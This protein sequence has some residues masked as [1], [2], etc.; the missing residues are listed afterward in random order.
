MDT[1]RAPASLDSAT[2]ADCCALSL[3]SLCCRCAVAAGNPLL[4]SFHFLP[5]LYPDHD[6]DAFTFLHDSLTAALQSYPTTL[7][8]DESEL[9]RDEARKAAEEHELPGADGEDHPHTLRARHR[10][11]IELRRSEKKLLTKAIAKAREWKEAEHPKIEQQ[12]KQKAGDQ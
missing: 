6:L 7:E 2:I 3:L 12:L 10:L 1:H 11:G 8:H 9:L 4:P 5:S